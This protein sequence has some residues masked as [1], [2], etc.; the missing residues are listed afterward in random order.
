[1]YYFYK[2]NKMKTPVDQFSPDFK[3]LFDKRDEAIKEQETVFPGSTELNNYSKDESINELM[4]I[5]NEISETSNS[6]II[7]FT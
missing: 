7:V 3:L 6:E 4:N 5:C 2:K 1:M